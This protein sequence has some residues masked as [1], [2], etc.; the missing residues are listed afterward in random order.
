MIDV[1]SNH[2]FCNMLLDNSFINSLIDNE[3]DDNE[4]NNMSILLLAG[5]SSVLTQQRSYCIRNR[6]D[7]D[8]HV[9]KLMAEHPTAFSRLY[10]MEYASFVKLCALLDPIIL[11]FQRQGRKAIATEVVLHCTLRWLAGGS[12]LDI[13][14]SAGISIPSFYQCV[15][16]CIN[17]I[18][19]CE[20]LAY[21]FPSQ[22]EDIEMAAQS[23]MEISTNHTIK[24]CVACVD[25]FLLKI[26]TSAAK[27]TGNV[28]SYF[29]GHYQAYGINIQ[30][31]CDHECRFLHVCVAAPGGVNDISAYRKTPLHEIVRNLPVGRYIIGDNAYV[32]TEHLLT[33]FSGNQ[34]RE[35]QKDTYN[36]YVS[37]LRMRIEMAFGLMVGK[38]GIL[39]HPLQ[40]KLK[41]TGKV[42][43]CI[44]RLHNFCINERTRQQQPSIGEGLAP[45]TPSDIG[46]TTIQG[47][48]T[49]RDMIVDHIAEQA[50]GRP[51][52]NLTRNR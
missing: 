40:T 23:F 16:R 26:Q 43:L 42:F 41:H 13:R 37:Q 51:Q 33:P 2:I 31:A 46:V 4:N 49:M 18:L 5:L 22:K 6:I 36:F 21:K 25:G 7:W 1:G 47:N 3:D 27:D 45:F 17:A 29:S 24:G 9:L 14:I 30:A 32:C 15:H 12:Y 44:T 28:K 48:S 39:Q 10:R 35:A 34:K 11:R 52:Q 19:F 50:L 20:S 8:I 38:W